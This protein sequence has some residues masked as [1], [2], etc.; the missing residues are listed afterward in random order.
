MQKPL[1]QYNTASSLVIKIIRFFL[2][3]IIN[4]LTDYKFACSTDAGRQMFYGNWQVLKNAI[5]YKKFVFNQFKR[6][7][8]RNTLN[9]A[10][11]CIV[12][13][14][15]GNFINQKNQI[16]L[17]Q[18]FRAFKCIMPAAKMIL[19]GADYGDLDQVKQEISKLKLESDVVILGDRSD[20]GDV[21][22]AFDVFV[23]PS[24]Y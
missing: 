5:D 18:I 9:I 13:G 22:C 19:V 20:V 6:I 21:L 8:L 15:V 17:I 24:H 14:N 7:E 16:F 10:E 23:F 3:I 1:G 12:L 11:T 2:K 4:G